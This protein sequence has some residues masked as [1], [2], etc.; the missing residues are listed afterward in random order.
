MASITT[1]EKHSIRSTL[2]CL[3][4]Y[5]TEAKRVVLLGIDD[6]SF[7]QSVVEWTIDNFSQSTD[8]L[9]LTTAIPTQDIVETFYGIRGKH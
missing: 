4:E 9:V 5:T 3:K 1:N 2:R 6:S 7:S 8:L